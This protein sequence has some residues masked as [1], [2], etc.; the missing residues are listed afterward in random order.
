M[1]DRPAL[2][3]ASSGMCLRQAALALNTNAWLRHTP[4]LPPAFDR[5]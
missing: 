4:P 3:G 5:A 2:G 1:N